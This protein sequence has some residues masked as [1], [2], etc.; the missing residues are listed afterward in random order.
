MVVAESEVF[1]R[2]TN[3][4]VD[5]V[6]YFLPCEHDSVVAA[7]AP[8]RAVG[9]SRVHDVATFLGDFNR[10]GVNL[11]GTRDLDYDVAHCDFFAVEVCCSFYDRLAADS[12]FVGFA[13]CC[14]VN[15]DVVIAIFFLFNRSVVVLFSAVGTLNLGFLELVSEV[16]AKT[17]VNK[18][19]MGFAGS[20]SLG[21]RVEVE[22]A[23][24]NHICVNSGCVGNSSECFG[25]VTVG[26]SKR[27]FV[28]LCDSEVVESFKVN[29]RVIRSHDAVLAIDSLVVG[30][31][32]N[33]DFLVVGL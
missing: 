24:V 5:L 10:V 31:Q 20:P 22:F 27:Q 4:A 32:G 15:R 28:L 23:S 30:L 21:K 13:V 11:C 16:F 8:C 3:N 2:D 26:I 19:D 14:I 17:S 9:Q 29:N 25:I 12:S 18:A 33:E 1:G 7:C 6:I